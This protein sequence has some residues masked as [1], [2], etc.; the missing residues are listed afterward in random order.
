MRVPVPLT[1]SVPLPIPCDPGGRFLKT[2]LTRH[3]EGQ[4]G[5][6][7]VKVYLKRG[8]PGAGGGLNPDVVARH[9]RRL[10]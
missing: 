3:E 8:A 4:G 5:L 1:A 9:E 6:V 10:R 7:V 2:Y